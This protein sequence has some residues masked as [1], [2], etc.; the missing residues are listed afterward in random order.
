[1]TV[2]ELK[3]LKEML[4][5]YPDDMEVTTSRYSDY[6]TVEEGEW[7]IVKGVDND[8]CYIMQSHPTMSE[9][10]KKNEKEYLYLE[11]N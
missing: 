5:K 3:E 7:S 11:G 8:N 1:M 2:K 6:N 9:E 10:H 4:N